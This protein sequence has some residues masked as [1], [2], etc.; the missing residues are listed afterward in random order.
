MSL[1]VRARNRYVCVAMPRDG[2]GFTLLEVLVAIAIFAI[3]GVM[4]LTGY[5][6]L[7]RQSEYS[8]QRLERVREVQR[9]VQTLAQDLTQIEPRPIREPIGE[10]RVPAVVAGESVDYA[11]EFTRAG[12]SNTAGLPRPTLQRVGYRVAEDAL[13]RDHW[14]VLDR[15]QSAEP[16]RVRLLGGV[17]EIRLRYLTAN[18]QWTD[19]WPPQAAGTGT[20]VERMRPAAVEV[21][22]DLEDWG[23]IK[24]LVEVSG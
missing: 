23:Q 20:A 10:Q 13:W 22:L 3:I 1:R 21:T 12:W 15:T 7:Q 11:I 8:Q 9:A 14:T 16:V 18:R 4:A 6:Q 19:R 5:T 24:R 2:H 17:R